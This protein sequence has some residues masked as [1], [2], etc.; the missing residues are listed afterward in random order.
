MIPHRP[1]FP[2]IVGGVER[3]IGRNAV[4]RDFSQGVHCV[5]DA[6]TPTFLHIPGGVE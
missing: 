5:R 6:T 2:H 1:H 4:Q 3:V